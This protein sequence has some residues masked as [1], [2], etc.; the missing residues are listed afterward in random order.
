MWRPWNKYRQLSF[1]LLLVLLDGGKVL[2][3]FFFP[4]GMLVQGVLDLMLALLDGSEPN[5]E[6]SV[7][8]LLLMVTHGRQ[9]VAHVLVMIA[10]GMV[11]EAMSREGH[12]SSLVAAGDLLKRLLLVVVK[13]VILPLLTWPL[14]PGTL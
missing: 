10:R 2:S 1:L 13:I 3:C 5:V 12:A 6:A 14:L 11:M 9:M 8:H 7:F 4:L